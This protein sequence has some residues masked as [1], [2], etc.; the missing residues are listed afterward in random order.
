MSGAVV[1]DD[2]WMF[3]GKVRSVLLEVA[4]RVTLRAHHVGDDL[5]GF[6]DRRRGAFEEA[7]FDALPVGAIA[8]TLGC[9]ERTNGVALDFLRARRQFTLSLL[10]T[11]HRV[12]GVV[13]FTSELV[14]QRFT[15]RTARTAREESDDD[16]QR[17]C[18][19]AGPDPDGVDCSE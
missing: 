2:A 17:Q 18:A 7:R 14:A 10:A 6:D 3:D 8:F 11:A 9:I 15:A 1:L 4:H 13:I 19:E 16:D 12:H 5:V